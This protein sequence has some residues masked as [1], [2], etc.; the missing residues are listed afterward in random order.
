[1]MLILYG[2]IFVAFNLL[3]LGQAA[4]A[5]VRKVQTWPQAAARIT[6]VQVYEIESSSSFMPSS[7]FGVEL[8]YEYVVNEVRYTSQQI[9]DGG[10]FHG[11]TEQQIADSVQVCYPVGEELWIIYDPQNPQVTLLGIPDIRTEDLGYG[12][13]FI[14]LGA[15]IA[16]IWPLLAKLPG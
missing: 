9:L 11:Q 14:V 3:S 13:I 4:R 2:S 1:M 8:A 5:R 10:L 6:S 16:C 7:T 12:L 15:G